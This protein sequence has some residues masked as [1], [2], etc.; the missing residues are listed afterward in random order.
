M[1]IEVKAEEG[2]TYF[3]SS[4]SSCSFSSLFSVTLTFQYHHVT[5]LLLGVHHHSIPE[6]YVQRPFPPRRDTDHN[7]C[8]F[9]TARKRIDNHQGYHYVSVTA[10]T[11]ITLIGLPSC[12]PSI[13]FYVISESSYSGIGL[14]TYQ[15]DREST[16]SATSTPSQV[17]RE[18]HYY[19]CL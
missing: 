19:N 3:A 15:F 11:S 10:R 8:W 12:L 18:L 16:T 5:M 14:E 7:A 4:R 2:A 17:S 13:V 1:R 9:T 6:H